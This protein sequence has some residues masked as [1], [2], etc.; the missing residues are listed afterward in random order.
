[1]IKT[2]PLPPS[3]L[4][5]P[6]NET[7]SLRVPFFSKFGRSKT[8]FSLENRL[9]QKLNK[10]PTLTPGQSSW[11]DIPTSS[12]RTNYKTEAPAPPL[13]PQSIS[14]ESHL[15]KSQGTSPKHPPS[16]SSEH[17]YGNLNRDT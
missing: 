11:S 13:L 4:P 16:V 9:A 17:S 12:N 1:M 8:V 15:P 3:P 10:T 2:A 14:L 6:L 7:Y 5:S